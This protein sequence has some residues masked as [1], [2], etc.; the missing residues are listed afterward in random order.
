MLTDPLELER[1][2][3]VGAVKGADPGY[4]K[5][6][7]L[8]LAGRLA[9]PDILRQRP[10]PRLR[11]TADVRSPANSRSDFCL[12]LHFV[13]SQFREL[14]RDENTGYRRRRIHRFAPR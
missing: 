11:G 7:V 1:V 13:S 10:Y 4:R 6:E 8:R 9:L 12:A 2:R 5:G 14:S 3:S